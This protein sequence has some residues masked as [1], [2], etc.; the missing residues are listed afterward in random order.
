VAGIVKGIAVDPLDVKKTAYRK[1]RT[2]VRTGSMKI[3]SI[4]GLREKDR[5]CGYSIHP[6]QK[7]PTSKRLAFNLNV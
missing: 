6:K 4:Y 3:D 1:R 5:Y 7:R 2:L